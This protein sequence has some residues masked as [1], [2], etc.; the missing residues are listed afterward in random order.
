MVTRESMVN[1][2]GLLCSSSF[3]S[4]SF[5]SF[6]WFFLSALLASWLG[7]CGRTARTTP[8]L[9][10]PTRWPA[11]WGWLSIV[12]GR[13]ALRASCKT[14]G[15]APGT[16]RFS[17]CTLRHLLGPGLFGGGLPFL[18]S[19]FGVSAEV[20]IRQDLHGGA[21]GGDGAT[22]EPYSPSASI[23]DPLSKPPVVSRDGSVHMGQRTVHVTE[24][25]WRQGGGGPLSQPWG[26]NQQESWFPEGCRDLVGAGSRSEGQTALLTGSW[27]PWP[28]HLQG[29]PGQW[30][31]ELSAEPSPG[32]ASALLCGPL[33]FLWSTSC[34]NSKSRLWHLSGF[35]PHFPGRA[36]IGA[37]VKLP[38]SPWCCHMCFPCPW[39]LGKCWK[40]LHGLAAFL[41]DR[42]ASSVCFLLF[43]PS[44][45]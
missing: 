45:Y 17:P 38:E 37:L 5:L 27:T 18:L 11:H 22:H 29:F 13:G 32:S 20:E 7:V 33:L 19:P 1:A 23:S 12:S 44:V 16:C 42:L 4:L 24:S 2:Q 26:A 34:S 6:Y 8:W 3:F 25:C 15:Q 41:K 14:A 21:P 39:E 36:P 30:R 28:S 43:C 31:P 9:L 35:L 40:E 10:L